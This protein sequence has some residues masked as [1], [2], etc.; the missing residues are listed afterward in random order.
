MAL[1]FS[2][3]MTLLGEKGLRQLAMINHANAVQLADEL[4]KIKGVSVLNDSFFNEF[5]VRLPTNAHD[6]VE[7]LAE[8]GALVGVPVSRLM[9]DR[10]EVENLLLVAVTELNTAEEIKALKGTIEGALA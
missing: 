10:K 3:H 2:I 7:A 8:Q 1:A 9:P 4:E 5:T 6:L